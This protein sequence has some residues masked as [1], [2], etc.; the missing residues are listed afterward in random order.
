MQERR[1]KGML[2]KIKSRLQAI[3]T[4]DDRRKLL[5]FAVF[6]ALM[7]AVAFIMTI[8]NI[9]TTQGTLTVVTGIYSVLFLINIFTIKKFYIPATVLFSAETQLLFAYFIVTG[10]PEGFS[11]L[12]TLLV[13]SFAMTVFK[14]RSGIRYTAITFLMIIF[15]FW[16]PIGRGLLMYSYNE[17]F[18]LRFPFVYICLAL[19]AFYLEMI[20]S[21]TLMRLRETENSYR[22]LYRHDALTGIFNRHAFYEEIEKVFE[23]RTEGSSF[24]LMMIDIDEFKG[25]NDRYGHSAGDEVLIEATKI[26]TGSTCDHS[27]ACRWGGEE[28]L[29]LMYCEHDPYTVAE[30]IRTTAE[31]STV[32][33]RDMEIRFTLSIGLTV[34][35]NVSSTHINDYISRAD[36][37]MYISKNKGRNKTTINKIG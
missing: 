11:V 34:G 16:L 18:M 30:R 12:W 22:D 19:V 24:A 32:R 9:A 5:I 27:I 23:N 8:V 25:I 26:I 29:V 10:D 14:G 15:F 13:P 20:R 21:A 37:A 31:S 6:N 7:A 17:T 33:F 4:D 3:V 36:S 1:E 2:E 28:F 35:K